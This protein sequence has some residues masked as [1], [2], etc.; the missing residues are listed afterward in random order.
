MIV[1]PPRLVGLGSGH[2]MVTTAELDLESRA[3]SF[4]EHITCTNKFAGFTGGVLLTYIDDDRR[5]V[6]SS[7]VQQN[8]I[9]QAPLIGAAHR[10]ISWNDIAARDRPACSWRSS[11]IRTTAFWVRSA[12][13]AKRS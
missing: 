13:L 1:I 5:V 4:T 6:G 12:T 2:Y 3:V 9:G 8:G 10:T 11:T 7:G